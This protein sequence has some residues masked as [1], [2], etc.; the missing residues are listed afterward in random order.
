MRRGEPPQNL[1]SHSHYATEVAE[2]FDALALRVEA[3][4]VKS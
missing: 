3:T 4:Q 1:Q 2:I